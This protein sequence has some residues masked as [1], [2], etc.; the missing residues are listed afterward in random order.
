MPHITGMLLQAG[1]LSE[2]WYTEEGSAR[3]KEVHALTASYDL[4][5]VDLLSCAS[6]KYRGYLLAHAAAMRALRPEIIA[7][8]EARVHS[9]LRFGGRTDRVWRL[10]GRHAVCDEKTGG[11]EPAHAIQT[12]LQAILEAERWGISPASLGRYCLY[13]RGAGRYKLEE[14]TRG[15][16]LDRAYRIIRQCCV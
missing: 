9:V 1:E 3:G 5:A 7:V 6:P 14:F 2:A 10:D 8:E 12:A 15:R 11:P 16:D 4:G 13:L